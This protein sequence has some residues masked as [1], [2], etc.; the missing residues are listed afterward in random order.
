V[1]NNRPDP[2]S[3]PPT[4]RWVKILISVFIVLVILVVIAHL[5]GFGMGGHGMS[6]QAMLIAYL[7]RVI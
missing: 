6:D 3:P 2:N 5:L 4:P 1:S 7:L